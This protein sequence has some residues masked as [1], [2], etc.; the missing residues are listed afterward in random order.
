MLRRVV[1]AIGPAFDRLAP[2]DADYATR[3]I[4]DAFDWQTCASLAASGEWYLVCFR[5]TRRAGADEARLTAMD[6]LA[7]AEAAGAPG[8]VHYFK[9]PTNERGECLSFCLWDSRAD[10]RAAAGRPQH[11]AA[12]TIAHETYE[13]YVLEFYRVRKQFGVPGFEFQPY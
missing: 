2:V 8:Y 12:V 1:M 4:A 11:V 6:D 13:S 7:H 3:P 5:S 10:A 9:G